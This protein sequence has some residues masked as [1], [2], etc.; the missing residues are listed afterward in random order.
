[1]NIQK[2]PSYGSPS[3]R[4]LI[5]DGLSTKIIAALQYNLFTN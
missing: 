4:S 5:E 2:Q 3:T 1:V